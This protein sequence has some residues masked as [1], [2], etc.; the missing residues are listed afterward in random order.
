MTSGLR[1][2]EQAH[3][4]DV[5]SFMKFAINR[6]DEVSF[7]RMVKL[8]P[9]VGGASATKLADELAADR[10]GECRSDDGQVQ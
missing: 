1:F 5:A 9:G 4:K 10:S 7:M 6:R 8:I 3:V 2:F